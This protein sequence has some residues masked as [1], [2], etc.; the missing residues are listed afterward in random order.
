MRKIVAID[1]PGGSGKSTLAEKLSDNITQSFII[2]TDYF[3]YPPIKDRDERW[4]P[5][6][7]PGY[8]VDW[9]RLRDQVIV[10][11]KKG[12]IDIQYQSLNWDN[13]GL[14]WV[15]IP[16][17]IDVLIIEGLY[18]FRCELRE[19]VDYSIWMDAN[20][21]KDAVLARVK[22][23]DGEEMLRYWT[24]EF[25]PISERYKEEH[26]TRDS[27]DITMDYRTYSDADIQKIVEAISDASKILPDNRRQICKP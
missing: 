13:W 16:N 3:T 4:W 12:A 24:E 27:V 21:D 18:S 9:E 6:D 15:K 20:S 17:K 5:E 2:G 19:L 8:G 25:I 26:K 14:D 7:I 23:R 11:F 10:P 1:A 22:E